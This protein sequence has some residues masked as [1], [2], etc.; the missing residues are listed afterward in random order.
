M[1][2]QL[3]HDPTFCETTF[4]VI[5]FE[6]T[7]PPGVRS[8]PIDVAAIWLTA[9]DGIP[10]PTGRRFEALIRPPAH[11]QVTEMDTRQTAITPRMVAGQPPAGEVLAKLDAG[12]ANGPHLLVAHNAPTEA[13]ILHDYRE[14]CPRLA[15]T[16]LLDTVRLARAAY[17]ELSSHS[18][19]VVL[20]HLRIPIPAGRHR[21]MPDVELTAAAF[22]RILADGSATRRWHRLADLRHVGGYQPKASKPMQESLFDVSPA[23]LT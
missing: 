17:P 3:S 22:A 14:S 5:D 8:E 21:A 13:G 16:Y 1:G 2:M 15:T 10:R 12:L 20:R 7:T 11:A 9:P 23:D 19:D 4:I 18:L 6:T